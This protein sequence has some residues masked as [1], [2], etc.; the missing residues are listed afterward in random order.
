MNV[1]EI[2]PGMTKEFM[3]SIHSELADGR[4]AVIET[5]CRREPGAPIPV[6]VGVSR[7]Q[8]SAQGEFCFTLRNIA[9]RRSAETMLRMEHQALENLACGIAFD[10]LGG[11]RRSNR[12]RLH[13]CGNSF[14]FQYFP[15]NNPVWHVCPSG[16][17]CSCRSNFTGCLSLGDCPFRNGHPEGSG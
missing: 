6:E 8:L 3:G 10:S 7:V 14:G 16:N 4:F 5:Y 17:Y 12:G 13:H 1:Q 11:S 2:A 9:Q 15:G